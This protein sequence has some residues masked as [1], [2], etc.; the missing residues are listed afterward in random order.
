MGQWMSLHATMHFNMAGTLTEKRQNIW[1]ILTL[2]YIQPRQEEYHPQPVPLSG[3]LL[4]HRLPD[5]RD[6][7]EWAKVD[8]MS[9]WHKKMWNM[10]IHLQNNE[11]K[12]I[13]LW[14]RIWKWKHIKPVSWNLQGKIGQ[15]QMALRTAWVTGNHL[16]EQNDATSKKQMAS[17]VIAHWCSMIIKTQRG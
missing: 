8:S 10:R 4:E 5:Y 12:Y 9:N 7:V 14:F 6:Q 16:M 1:K 3:R 17:W 13:F 15:S 2:Q 11:M